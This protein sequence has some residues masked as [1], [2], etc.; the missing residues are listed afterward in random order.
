VHILNKISALKEGQIRKRE[1][2]LVRLSSDGQII[3]IV[4]RLI[5]VYVYA[6][7]TM[8]HIH[9]YAASD[10]IADIC[11]SPSDNKKLYALTGNLINYNLLARMF[12][13]WFVSIVGFVCTTRTAIFPR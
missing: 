10:E 13:Y 1:G 12:S 6:F 5:E 2:H 4:N 9:T 11:F 7:K 3:A 8:E